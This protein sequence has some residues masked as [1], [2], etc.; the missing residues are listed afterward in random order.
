MRKLLLF[1]EQGFTVL[2]LMIYTG[3]P[4]T[5]ILSGGASEGEAAFT[6]A[7]D[8][9]LIKLILLLNYLVS[10][11]LLIIRWKKVLYMLSKDRF[12]WVI[13]GFAVASI[14]WSYSPDK[15]LARVLALV[16]TTLFGLYLTTRYTLKQQLQLLGWMFCLVIVLSF[17]FGLALRQYGIM[18]G[19]HVGAWRGIYNHKNV[20][21]KMMIMSASIFLILAIGAKKNRLF[22]WCGFGISLI[23]VLLSRSSSS[24]VNFIIILTAFFVF[25]TLRWRYELMIPG[26]I[27]LAMV[28]GSLF[29]GITDNADALLGSVGK[30]ATLTGRTDLWPLVIGEISKRPWLG[31][32]YGGFWYGWDSAASDIWYASGWNPPNS[33]NGLL[34]LAIQLGILGVFMFGL[35]FLTFS[36]PRA[37]IWVRQSRTSDGF[38]PSLFLI[39]FVLAN[40]TEST[41]ML[42]NDIFW[43]LYVAINYTIL[44]PP[45]KC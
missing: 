36:V 43:V 24:L 37:L 33:H 17:I 16:G 45:E 22:L 39:N 28:G 41:L 25:R 4:L 11:F 13:V 20:L 9:S 6:D 19:V 26:L 40:L 8:N 12:I 27:V 44:M 1:A 18:G 10:F 42:Q 5:V 15:T 30:D 38:W 29:L 23:L 34:D 7:N 32:G 3:G 2:S 31:Y 35:G 21:G 14:L